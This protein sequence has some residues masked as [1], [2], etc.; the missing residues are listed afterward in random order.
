MPSAETGLQFENCRPLSGREHALDRDAASTLL[1]GL[2]G[3]TIQDGEILQKAFCFTRYTAGVLF[4]NTLAA[5]AE[6]ENHHPHIEMSYGRVT[7]SYRT[8]DVDGLS[9]N[10]FICAAKAEALSKI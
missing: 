8:H 2:P 5:L 6:R 3:W 10:D 1:A 7:V 9:R 4:V